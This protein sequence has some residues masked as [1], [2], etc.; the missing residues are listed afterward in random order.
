MRNCTH[1]KPLFLL[2]LFPLPLLILHTQARYRRGEMIIFPP[3][4]RRACIYFPSK[5]YFWTVIKHVCIIRITV[6]YTT[7]NFLKL[8]EERVETLAPLR[9][10][11]P[12]QT[13]A[14]FAHKHIQKSQNSCFP[15][16]QLFKSGIKRKLPLFKPWDHFLFCSLLYQTLKFLTLK[17]KKDFA[18]SF[19]I[20][21]F[22]PF[23]LLWECMV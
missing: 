22:P 10:F 11:L 12:K 18:L 13:H 21:L 2:F 8:L 4:K 14:R 3:R 17:L 20:R 15:P 16:P 6:K 7:C 1:Q 23:S 19:R 5:K 9:H